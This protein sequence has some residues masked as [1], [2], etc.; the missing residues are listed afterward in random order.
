MPPIRGSSVCNLYAGPFDPAAVVHAV[1]QWRECIAADESG[2]VRDADFNVCVFV[3]VW[4]IRP[5]VIHRPDFEILYFC[6]PKL[7]MKQG[8]VYYFRYT[9]AP[10]LAGPPGPVSLFSRCPGSSFVSS[11]R[12]TQLKKPR[13][14]SA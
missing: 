3:L 6:I 1:L 14:K 12:Q 10:V 4:E 7:V 11:S 13:P 9:A 8:S 5:E 2:C